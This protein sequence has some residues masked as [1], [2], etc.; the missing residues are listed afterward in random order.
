MLAATIFSWYWILLGTS[1]SCET[2]AIYIVALIYPKT[3][4]TDLDEGLIR[5]MLV[6]V[7]SVA[8]LLLYFMRRLCFMFNSIFAVFKIVL[9]LVLIAAGV[10]AS[11]KAGSGMSDFHVKQAGYGGINSLVAMIYVV[12]C[13]QGWEHTNYVSL[14]ILRTTWAANQT[15]SR[16]KSRSQRRSLNGACSFP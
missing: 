9:L 14:L 12:Y 13:Y 1:G 2:V 5:F 16:A 8:C 11:H 15:R 7:Q 3:P 10:A 4:Y 6:I